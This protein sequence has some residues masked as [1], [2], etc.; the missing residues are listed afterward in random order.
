M[1]VLSRR[2]GEK[3]IIGD[4][5][6]ITIVRVAQGTVRIGVDA[7]RDMMVVRQE[8]AD[9]KRDSSPP[10]FPETPEND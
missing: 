7:P 9:A 5:I 1:L 6:T 10:A 3:I 8:V 2:V 4:D